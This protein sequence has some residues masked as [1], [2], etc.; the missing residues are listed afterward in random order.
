MGA[1]ELF[2]QTIAHHPSGRLFAVCGD[3]EYVIYTAQALRNKSFGQAVGFAWS[4]EGHYATRDA[5]GKIS[6]F[7]NFKEAFSFKTDFA[8]D[9]IHSGE[10]LCV[11]GPDYVVFYDWNE[12]RVIRR[13]DVVATDVFWSETGKFCSITASDN[14]YMLAFDRSAVVAAAAGGAHVEDGIEIAFELHNEIQESVKSGVWIGDSCFVFVND[15]LKLNTLVGGQVEVVAHLDHSVKVLGFLAEHGKVY[16]CDKGLNVSTFALDLNLVK[17]K[18]AI[19]VHDLATAESLFAAIPEKLHT[20]VARFLESQGFRSEALEITKDVDHKFELAVSVGNLELA[21]QLVGAAV[22]PA[23]LVKLKQVGDKAIETG[24]LVLAESCFLTAKDSSSLL[25]LASCT[26]DEKLLLKTADI[27]REEKKLNVE[28]MARTLVGDVHGCV[29]ALVSAGLVA[30]AALYAR[31]HCPDALKTV[32]PMWKAEIGKINPQLANAIADPFHHPELFPDMGSTPARKV[33]PTTDSSPRAKA[34]VIPVPSVASK[35][36]VISVPSA[37]SRA[38]VISAP[39]VDDSP[40]FKSPSSTPRGASGVSPKTAVHHQPAPARSVSPPTTT[41]DLPVA[42]MRSVSPA[43]SV[44]SQRLPTPPTIPSR[45]SGLSGPPPAG[46]P[47]SLR[48]P[49]PM[50]SRISRP[51]ETHIAMPTPES[52]LPPPKAPE[53]T[54]EDMDLL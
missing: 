15:K 22:D 35:A 25:L 54:N 32:F 39:A 45:P 1:C 53:S 5:G 31:S 38:P 23:A 44:P 8:I 20:K 9:D 14:M 47:S 49:P 51:P 36:P 6:V 7:H 3:G 18:A 10:L 48:G 37:A 41:R 21:R 28:L 16:C 50:P 29:D 2:P 42:P 19:S 24:D 43:T 52:Q 12:Y 17:Y 27:A 26:G 4:P 13:I 30:E 11:R 46:P 40:M 34:P 33:A